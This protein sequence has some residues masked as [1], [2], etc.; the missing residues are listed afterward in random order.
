MKVIVLGTGFV[1][2]THAAVL[3]ERG[4]NVV[5]CDLDSRKLAA[6]S[7]GEAEQIEK[8]VN[9]PGLSGCVRQALNSGCLQFSTDATPH[10]KD[11]AAVFLC[12]PTPASQSGAANLTQYRAS[13][14]EL[15]K[16]LSNSPRVERLILINKNTVPIGTTRGLV[17]ELEAAG[18][19][20]VGV[21][22]NPEFLPQGEAVEAS[23]RPSRVV[24]GAEHE[25]DFAIMRRLYAPYVDHGRV[26]YLETTPETAEAVKYVSNAL[27]FTYVS[28]WNGVAARL[29]ET[30]ESVRMNDLRLGVTS[31]TRISD[32]GSHVGNG[33]GG[34]CLG[35]DLRSL[36][37]QM[38]ALGLDTDLLSDV[39]AI[40]EV[41]KTHLIERAE[42]ELGV[43][44]EGKTVA[45]AGLSFK[46]NTN[47]LHD[48][49]AVTLIE[50]LLARGVKSI[51]AY[52]PLVTGE[53]ARRHLDCGRNPAFERVEY[54]RAA[55]RAIEGSEALFISNDSD[56]FHGL[57][58]VIRQTVAPPYAVIDGRRMLADASVLIQA[59]YGY[60]CVGES[61]RKTP[62]SMTAG[63][64]VA[65]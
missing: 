36:A 33:A 3:A 55:Q 31:D 19:R 52:D 48:S 65:A 25:A 1:G 28:F 64:D 5:A 41:Q 10:L 43:S 4:L 26:G 30:I 49:P 56:E 58:R 8:Y 23:R 21:A 39:L 34:S 50:S 13:I 44:F 9:E 59:G 2:L 62:A 11:A 22:A 14:R 40:N 51:R 15:I 61:A 38:R 16:A 45:I 37:F 46:K 18:I 7:S 32:W 12:L 35:K 42:Q 6:F 20:E 47:D 24:V 54:F 27:L 17:R 60:L 53:C 63:E 57:T 29:G